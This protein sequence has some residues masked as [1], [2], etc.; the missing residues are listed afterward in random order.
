MP[1]RSAPYGHFIK[2][3]AQ[4]VSLTLVVP[5]DITKNNLS[6]KERFHLKSEVINNDKP[7]E[8]RTSRNPKI[9]QLSGAVTIY[10]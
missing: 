10:N 8:A 7:V 6:G 2:A 1:T 9:V 5:S 3:L 4:K